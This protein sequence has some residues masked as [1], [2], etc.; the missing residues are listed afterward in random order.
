MT[1]QEETL[2]GMDYQRRLLKELFRF[3]EIAIVGCGAF[4]SFEKKSSKN[5]QQ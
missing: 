3:Y 2:L 1:L 4:P 5:E